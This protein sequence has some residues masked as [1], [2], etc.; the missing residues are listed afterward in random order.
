MIANFFVFICYIFS[1]NSENHGLYEGI[2]EQSGNFRFS[3]HNK[4]S[5]FHMSAIRNND[6]LHL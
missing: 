5:L 6:I 1:H 4:L 3:K 2:K